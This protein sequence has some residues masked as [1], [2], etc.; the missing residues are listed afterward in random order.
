MRCLRDAPRSGEAHRQAASGAEL[1]ARPPVENDQRPAQHPAEVGEVRHA[2]LRAREP[3]EQLDRGID[4]DEEPRRHRDRYRQH[5]ETLAWEIIGEG[6][7][8]AEHS[9][10]GPEYRL[11]SASGSLDE[12]LRYRCRQHAH[13]VIDEEAPPAPG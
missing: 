10:R 12:Q 6:E 4:R 9:A 7:Q 2:L 11:A 8:Y 1:A 5:D 3:G 13:E